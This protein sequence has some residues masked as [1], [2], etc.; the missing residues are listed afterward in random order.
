MDLDIGVANVFSVD[1]KLDPGQV[2][3]D[4]RELFDAHLGELGRVVEPVQAVLQK[5]LE[6]RQILFGAKR[7]DGIAAAAAAHNNGQRQR[8]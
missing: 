8:Q 3:A 7:S 1:R 4:R 6:R 5:L 2:V